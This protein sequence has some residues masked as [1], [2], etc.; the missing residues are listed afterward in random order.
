MITPP[1]KD[2][3]F[4]TIGC[5]S[6]CEQY[7]AFQTEMEK[8][9]KKATECALREDMFRDVERPQ[10]RHW[11]SAKRQKNDITKNRK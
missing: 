9:R 2:C 10:C 11:G 7:K 4:R 6:S 3:E 1:C 8:I 5:H